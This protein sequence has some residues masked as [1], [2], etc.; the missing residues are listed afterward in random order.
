MPTK[1]WLDYHTEYLPS[2]RDDAE[3]CDLTK[4]DI[5]IYVAKTLHQG[6][7]VPGYAINGVG[8]FVSVELQPFQTNHFQ[9]CVGTFLKFRQNNARGMVADDKVDESERITIG[10]FKIEEVRY[11]GMIDNQ[12]TCHINLDDQVYFKG[13]PEFNIFVE[14]K[15]N[16]SD[17]LDSDD[18][19]A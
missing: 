19:N 18:E 7:T 3:F 2:G 9:V 4:D 8:Y 11:C 17:E 5:P 10:S 15:T 14:S 12:N 1:T 16:D 13:A 6:Y